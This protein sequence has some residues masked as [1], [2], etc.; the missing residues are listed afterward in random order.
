[1]HW[2]T[3]E[4]PVQGTASQQKPEMLNVQTSLRAGPD[5]LA[6]VHLVASQ[7]KGIDPR[8]YEPFPQGRAGKKRRLELEVSSGHH[9]IR[10]ERNLWTCTICQRGPERGSLHDWL[11]LMC[12]WEMWSGGRFGDE[13]TRV[14]ALDAAWVQIGSQTIHHTHQPYARRGIVWCGV[15]G[16]YGGARLQHSAQPFFQGPNAQR[17]DVLSRLQR[18]LTPE[19]NVPCTRAPGQCEDVI[20][21]TRENQG[22]GSRG[23]VEKLEHRTRLAENGD[24]SATPKMMRNQNSQYRSMTVC[25]PQNP[26]RT[27][28]RWS[29]K[30]DPL[31]WGGALDMTEYG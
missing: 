15:C 31:G 16:A 18:E 14:R 6:M 29:T 24:G 23:P 1:M 7:R 27:S 12:V 11:Q 22:N 13:R 17:R 4:L 28:V 10:D 8:Q 5:K 21:L 20:D 3:R 30:D 26:Q 2:R 25:N 19:S 9:K